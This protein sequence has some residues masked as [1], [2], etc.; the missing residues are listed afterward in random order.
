MSEKKK[1][2]YTK[3]IRE[4]EQIINEVETER[5]DVDALTEKV[6]R[7]AD[8]IKYCKGNLRTTEEEV[9]KALSEIQEKPEEVAPGET[10][11]AETEP[12]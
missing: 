9:K 3:A 8:L 1:L 10:E 11:D 12:F 6:K 2:T 5:I 4:L 7:A